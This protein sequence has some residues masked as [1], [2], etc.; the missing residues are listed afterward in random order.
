[1]HSKD[2]WN[3]Q[4]RVALSNLGTLDGGEGRGNWCGGA[5]CAQ[6]RTAVCTNGAKLT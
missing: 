5:K 2:Y 4:V 1:M 6:M 3:L